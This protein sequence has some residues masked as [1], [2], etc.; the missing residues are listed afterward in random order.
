MRETSTGVWLK[1]VALSDFLNSLKCW[2][3][4]F[5]GDF[6]RRILDFREHTLIKLFEVISWSLFIKQWIVKK[7]FAKDSSKSKCVVSDNMFPDEG[8]RWHAEMSLEPYNKHAIINSYRG[9]WT[10]NFSSPVKSFHHI[11]PKA[12]KTVNAKET[13]CAKEAKHL[14]HTS[15]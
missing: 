12:H 1:T 3:K 10:V 6:Y 13:C 5:K 11:Y 9:V 14:H 8:S 7:V 4:I 15:H 2:C